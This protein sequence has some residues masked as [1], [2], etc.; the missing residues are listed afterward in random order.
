MKWN[1]WNKNGCWSKMP[2]G[3]TL[4]QVLN[5]RQRI[6]EL[7]MQCLLRALWN[8]FKK[9]HLDENHISG[10]GNWLLLPRG[11]SKDWPGWRTFATLSYLSSCLCR[12][13]IY[14]CSFKTLPCPSGAPKS[15]TL[16]LSFTGILEPSTGAYDALEKKPEGQERFRTYCVK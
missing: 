5:V 12:G 6:V 8:K 1:A 9:N 10:S 3:A 11:D 4:W 13:V 2:W 15:T 7:V 16:N 14:I